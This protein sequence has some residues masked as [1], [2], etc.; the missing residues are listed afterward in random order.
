MLSLDL[1]SG[2]SVAEDEHLCS[3]LCSKNWELEIHS[4]FTIAIRMDIQGQG[5]GSIAGYFVDCTPSEGRDQVCFFP[6][7]LHSACLDVG[8]WQSPSK[9]W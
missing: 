7:G 1:L 3:P 4:I 5:I 8:S 9:Y 2:K 6:F